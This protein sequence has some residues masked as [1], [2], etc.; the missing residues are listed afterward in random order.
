MLSNATYLYV[1]ETP[2]DKT[3]KMAC[4][5]SEDSGQLEHP[6]S[7]IR[8]F[9]VRMKKALVLS[10]PL[11]AQRR[12]SAQ[13]DQSLRWGHSH[14]VGFLMRRLIKLLSTDRMSLRFDADLCGNR[15]FWMEHYFR[16]GTFCEVHDVWI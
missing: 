13:S 10:Y 4:S 9:A 2:P 15:N 14:F 8:V 6:P 3:N 12:L 7:L 11:S 1:K 5:P 16:L